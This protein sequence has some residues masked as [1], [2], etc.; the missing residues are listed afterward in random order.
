VQDREISHTYHADV[1]T[2]GDV[3]SVRALNRATLARQLLLR[4]RRQPVD[5]V[6]EHLV[7][8]QGQAPNAPYVG[9]WSRIDGFRA[10]ELAALV[11][12]RRAVRAS[13]MR[14]TVHL[15]TA[16]DALA[17]RPLVQPVLV[18]NFS[19]QAFNRNLAGMDLDELLAA[20]RELLAE[21]PRSRADL[22][23][24]L[25]QRF[26]GRDP[27]S[28]AY[29]V[30]YLIPLVQVPPRGI[31][32]ASGPAALAPMEDW[33]GRPLERDPA[34]DP[35]VLRY[36]GAFGP[37]SVKDA[38]AWSGLTRLREVVDRLRPDLRTFRDEQG[39]ELFDLPDAPRPDP[40]TPAPVVFLPEYDNLL[41]SHADRSRVKTPGWP[42][43]LPAGN[44]GNAGTVLVDG[45]FR[46][47][48]ATARDGGRVTLTVRPFAR[49][50][51][52]DGA[53]VAAEAE[54]LLAFTDPAAATRDVR[55]AAGTAPS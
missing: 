19:G 37:A 7:G 42:V 47:T 9:L 34:P 6:I 29:A 24:L 50:S 10:S 48:W 21:A 54:R 1:E 8:M 11:S 18:R 17:L 30:S 46:A 12:D 15:V 35:V 5:E 32:G 51:P 45:Q 3:L 20:G 40:D 36:L 28:M 43:P 38:Q 44:G 23:P 13:L 26:P 2:A 14:A 22:G 27:T 41:L 4:R 33:L 16:R 31:W 55:L 39:V 52:S 53:A 25:A 49:L